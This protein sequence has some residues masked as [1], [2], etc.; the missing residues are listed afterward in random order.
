MEN[1]IW[2]EISEKGKN[3]LRWLYRETKTKAGISPDSKKHCEFLEMLFG[4][5]NIFPKPVIKTWEDISKNDDLCRTKVWW[6]DNGIHTG[7]HFEDNRRDKKMIIKLIST[8]KIAQLIKFGYGGF[9]TDEEWRDRDIKK[10]VVLCENRDGGWVIT[11]GTT[12][13]E[14]H[15]IAFH[16]RKQCED[17]LEH[18]MSLCKQYYMI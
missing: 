15:F 8:I 1:K 4:E 11:T 18:N 9:I 2:N 13:E 12:F 14:Y 7:I 16:T 10:H 5:E 17:F 6:D 3:E